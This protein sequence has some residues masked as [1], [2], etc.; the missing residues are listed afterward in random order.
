MAGMFN[1]FNMA[2]PESAEAYNRTHNIL[3]H[4]AGGPNNAMNNQQ[5]RKVINIPALH[6][7]GFIVLSV[8][9]PGVSDSQAV[10][11]STYSLV[12][13]GGSDDPQIPPWGFTF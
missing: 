10:V 3:S 13:S 11:A 6:A 4:K 7:S 2:Q 9:I 12:E 8:S 1:T 5:A